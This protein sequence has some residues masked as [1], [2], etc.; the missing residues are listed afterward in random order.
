MRL[1]V[2][3][4][5]IA[6]VTVL[7]LAGCSNGSQST[8]GSQGQVSYPTQGQTKAIP[9]ASI[10]QLEK[11]HLPVYP[12]AT[13]FPGG[14]LSQINSGSLLTL[15]L[16]TNDSTAAVVSYYRKHLA[17]IRNGVS[18]PPTVTTGNMEGATTTIITQNYRNSVSTV[19]IK[20]TSSGSN[21]IQLMRLPGGALSRSIVSTNLKPHS[22]S[23]SSRL[24]QQGLP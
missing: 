4:L 22:Q 21:T 19:E 6:A 20:P 7:V 15:M 13:T 23:D 11:L 24:D 10:Q 2:D 9:A 17:I 5:A 18:V 1:T 8:A 12:G 16:S 3:R 14:G